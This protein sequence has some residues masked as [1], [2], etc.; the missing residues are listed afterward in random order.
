MSGEILRPR[1]SKSSPVLTRTVS[2]PGSSARERPR[3]SLAPPIPP[4]RRQHRSSH[5]NMS[6]S[7][8]LT[9]EE[10]GTWL[11]GPDDAADVHS[12]QAFVGLTHQQR[13]G[14]GDLIGDRDL[15]HPHR[16]AEQIGRADQIP[17]RR[18]AGGAEGN[19][20]D[21][22]APRPTEAVVDDDA[23]IDAELL[24]E[25][26][27]DSSRPMHRAHRAAAG[28]R[29][30]VR[31]DVRLIDSGIRHHEAEA[32]SD[33]R[34]RPSCDGRL[35]SIRAGSPRRAV[36][37][38]PTSRASVTARGDGST[39]VEIDDASFGLR[40]DLLR[41][42]EDVAVLAARSAS[43]AA[44][45]RAARPDRRQEQ[46]SGSPSSACSVEP[47][48]AHACASRSRTEGP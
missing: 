37:S 46:S 23:E 41:N 9:S 45:P 2:S 14:R 17:E 43:V 34:A 30:A 24:V 4:H 5:R 31:A 39:S 27:L 16:P 13:R 25:P 18:N 10:A 21:A 22:I 44:R 40:H 33:D 28:T 15:G 36:A 38:L 6:I 26:C 8:G 12:G 35:R 29:A 7:L 47:S 42:D 48:R 11:R 20:H 19:A 1:C 32:M 3:A